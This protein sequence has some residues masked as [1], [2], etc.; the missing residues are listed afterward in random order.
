MLLSFILGAILI[1]IGYSQFDSTL[2]Q[3]I[4]LKIDEGAKLYS[5]LISLNAAVVLLLQLPISIISERF[6]STATLVVGVLFFA[7]GLFMFGF[8]T[9]YTLYIIGMIIFTIGEIFA[10]PT[11]NVMIDEIA[12]DTQKATYLGAAQFKNLGGF[13]GPIIG[14]WLLT[15]YMNAMFPVIAVLVLCSCIFYRTKTAAH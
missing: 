15:H 14:G 6:S 10:F 7:I 12:P 13:I 4:E 11:M 5:L 2:P 1:N 9:N 8:S 3:I